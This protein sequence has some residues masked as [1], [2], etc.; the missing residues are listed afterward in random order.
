VQIGVSEDELQGFLKGMLVTSNVPPPSE[1]VW[2]LDKDTTMLSWIAPSLKNMWGL[3]TPQE[4]R[5]YVKGPPEKM[6]RSQIWVLDRLQDWP[7]AAK[8]W[9]RLL[10]EDPGDLEAAIRTAT[11]LDDLGTDPR[12]LLGVIA[13]TSGRVAKNRDSRTKYNPAKLEDIR[14]DLLFRA[15]RLEEARNACNAAIELDES[16]GSYLLVKVLFAMGKK[17]EAL[18][19]ADLLAKTPGSAGDAGTLFTLGLA[20]QYNGLVKDAL[21]TWN[22]ALA[23]WPKF[24]I[25]LKAVSGPRRDVYEWRRLER[26]F[27]YSKMAEQLGR[28]G[29]YYSELGMHERADDCFRRAEA[30]VPGTGLA[31]QLVFLGVTK[32]DDALAKVTAALDHNQ[33]AN[34]YLLSAMAWL[35]LIKGKVEES[36]RWLVRALEVNP[37]DVKSTQLMWEVC[38]E[39]KDYVCVIEYRKRLGLPT[40]FNQEQ[41]RDVSKAWQEQARKNGVGLAAREPD[42]TI[43]AKPPKV[44]ATVIIPLGARVPPELAGLDKI[45]AEQLQGI[46]VSLG[47]LEELPEGAYKTDRDQVI[48]EVLLERL[49][50]EPGRI[51]VIEQ[52]LAAYESGFAYAKYDLAHGRAV[53][54]LARLRSFIG[55]PVPA[56]ILLDDSL[57]QPIRK[58]LQTALVEAAAK[59]N[60]L[61]FPCASPACAL[62]EHRAV[63]DFVLPTPAFCDKHQAELRELSAPLR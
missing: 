62:R 55:Q 17:K 61:S 41:Y 46:K 3:N 35:Q 25:L 21:V 7:T 34:V 2:P 11:L 9:K 27:W 29:F 12:V 6:N 45:L 54:S 48:W 42:S 40:H 47:A 33:H 44:A 28:C 52:D 37:R 16:Y 36:K 63:T 13:K 60:G 5:D 14:C 30:L 49:R 39:Q 23:R 18:V 53:V 1:P 15:R 59:L 22:V 31:H 38:G 57:L 20:Q 56:S 26:E 24:D 19:Q 58:R 51:Y 8:A 10:D 4:I 50:D 32:T 43:A